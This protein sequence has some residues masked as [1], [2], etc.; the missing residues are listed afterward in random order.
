VGSLCDSTHFGV[1]SRSDLYSL[2]ISFFELLTG[3]LPFSSSSTDYM[4]MVHSHLA[5]SLPLVHRMPAGRHL[6]PIIS[7]ILC[8]LCA[9]QPTHRYQSA[10]GLLMDLQLCQKRLVKAVLPPPLGSI[11][12]RLQSPAHCTAATASASTSASVTVAVSPAQTSTSIS[13]TTQPSPSPSRLG[14]SSS[15]TPA[16]WWHRFNSSPSFASRSS[17]QPIT[18]HTFGPSVSVP[19]AFASASNSGSASS[20]ASAATATPTASTSLRTP[21]LRLSLSSPELSPAPTG[22]AAPSPDAAATAT[23]ALVTSG[24]YN[25]VVYSIPEFALAQNDRLVSFHLSNKVCWRAAYVSSC[26]CDASE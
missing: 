22:S 3:A 25:S 19:S 5:L 2:G 21:A 26:L 8:K 13:A 11:D 6:P 20:T 9:K 17:T 12:A 24:A 18:S 14:A 7:S 1:D 10:R 23:A 15:A 16:M 4:Q